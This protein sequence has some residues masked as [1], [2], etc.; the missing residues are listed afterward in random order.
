MFTTIDTISYPEGLLNK[1]KFRIFPPKIK[2][3][4]I[5][6]PDGADFLK[7]KVPAKNDEINWKKVRKIAEKNAMNLVLPDWISIPYSPQ[8]EKFKSDV[9]PRIITVNSAKK[10]LETAC[11]VGYIFD[12]GIIDYCGLCCDLLYDFPEYAANITIVTMKPEKFE[13]FKSEAMKNF[14]IAV[15][16][17][18]DITKAFDLPVIIIPTP[19]STAT[20]FSR[21]SAI[22]AVDGKNIFSSRVLC[23]NKIN[24]PEKYKALLPK[25]VSPLYFASALYEISGV[26]SL[27]SCYSP[28]FLCGGSQISYQDA[29]KYLDLK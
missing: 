14:G 17:T 27:N 9:L 7:L 20:A 22:I 8:L 11:S 19:L 16:L 25:G 6:V 13:A 28:S 24:L 23:A 4:I 15:R 10:L 12:I 26:S 29:I 1:I 21:F 3:E 2:A 5:S 18:D